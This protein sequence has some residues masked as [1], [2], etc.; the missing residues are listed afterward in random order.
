MVVQPSGEGLTED[1]IIPV[2]SLS[3]ATG[4]QPVY[5]SF[6]RVNPDEYSLGSFSCLLKFVSKE[7]DPSS[8]EPEETGYDDEYQLEEMEL[9]AADW[10]VPSWASFESEWAKLDQELEEEFVLGSMASIKGTLQFLHLP[11][12]YACFPL[13]PPPSVHHLTHASL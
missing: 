8:G 4:T 1:L 7:V 6:T 12:T 11:I 13:S 9:G 5:V 2:A 3:I 10:I